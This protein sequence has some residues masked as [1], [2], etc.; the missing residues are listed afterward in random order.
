MKNYS[1]NEIV[2][3]IERFESKSLPKTEWTHEAHLVV[4]IWYSK[5]YSMTKAMDLVRNFISQHNQ[6]VGTPNSD[7]EGYH[8]SI[9]QFWLLTAERF[10]QNQQFDTTSAACNAFINSDEGNS[11]Y[12]L[13][14]YSEKKLFSVQARH[15]WIAPDKKEFA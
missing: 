2:D 6:S 7:T 11:N 15:H 4:A 10:S 14:F 13:N 3:L 12:P 5:K 8:E 1:D 9:T